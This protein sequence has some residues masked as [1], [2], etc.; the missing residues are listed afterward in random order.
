M[1]MESY[2]LVHF[3]CKRGSQK[4]PK[5]TPKSGTKFLILR[6]FGMVF[7]DGFRDSGFSR[8]INY[9][10]VCARM[11][12]VCPDVQGCVPGCAAADVRLRMC[13]CFAGVR[14]GYFLI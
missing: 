2:S 11:A 9:G 5:M 7:W 8:F 3:V 13:A 6:I 10:Q 4:G 12:R 14:R 1:T